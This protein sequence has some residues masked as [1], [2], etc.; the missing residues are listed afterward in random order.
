MCKAGLIIS[1]YL[2]QRDV[3]VYLQKENYQYDNED[4]ERVQSYQEKL[5]EHG[6]VAGRNSNHIS[7]SISIDSRDRDNWPRMRE[8]LHET[9]GKFRDILQDGA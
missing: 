1:Q 8:W 6:I 4:R 7:A 2:A 5:A 9:L 3:G